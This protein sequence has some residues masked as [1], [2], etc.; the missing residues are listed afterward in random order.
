MSPRPTRKCAVLSL[1]FP[2]T[3]LLSCSETMP[4]IRK[5]IDEDIWIDA[6]GDNDKVELVTTIDKISTGRITK[7]MVRNEVN[8]STMELFFWSD[9]RQEGSHPVLSVSVAIPTAWSPSLYLAALF[10]CAQ[11]RKSTIICYQPESIIR[12]FGESV[13]TCN[14]VQVFF[15]S[16]ASVLF[17]RLILK[18]AF[19]NI[20]GGGYIN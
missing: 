3:L 8:L 11:G 6:S 7:I 16:D 15:R 2:T 10:A 17:N 4:A 13:L 14:E 5:G 12:D 9:S 19:E 1:S 20:D 18:A